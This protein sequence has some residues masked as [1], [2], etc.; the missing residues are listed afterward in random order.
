MS[1]QRRT[2]IIRNSVQDGTFILMDGHSRLTIG[3]PLASF[4]DAVR[5]AQQAAGSGTIWR[6]N[7][8]AR[9]RPLGAPSPSRPR[10]PDSS[11]YDGPGT[12]RELLNPGTGL[13]G[14]YAKGDRVSNLE[15]KHHL[16]LVRDGWP[17]RRVVGWQRREPQ[18]A[19]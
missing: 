5:A 11:R 13:V 4:A 17:L 3:E 2:V 6:E 19:A 8:D 14:E 7:V 15:T 18:E 9:G 16:R 10:K 1:V 12:S